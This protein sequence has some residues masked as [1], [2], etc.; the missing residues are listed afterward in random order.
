[1]AALAGQV[2]LKKV[3]IA[4]SVTFFS[5]SSIDYEPSQIALQILLQLVQ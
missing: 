3:I 5:V 1:M 4:L 2:K